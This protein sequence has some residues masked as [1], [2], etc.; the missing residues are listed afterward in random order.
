MPLTLSFPLTVDADLGRTAQT[1]L[2]Q[3]CGGQIRSISFENIP[4]RHE[5]RLWVTLA[6]VAYG[7]ALHALILGL[8]AAEFGA[9]RANGFDGLGAQEQEIGVATQT[10]V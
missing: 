8:P 3:A 10:M 6:A 1:L 7:V 9:V 5:T 2:R 4:D